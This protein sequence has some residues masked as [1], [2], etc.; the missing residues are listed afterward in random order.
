MHQRGVNRRR[1]TRDVRSILPERQRPLE[2]RGV[3]VGRVRGAGGDHRRRRHPYSRGAK[4]C[5]VYRRWSGTGV[6]RRRF[7]QALVREMPHTL[8]LLQ[9]GRLN[10]WRATLLVR[11]TACLSAADR[12]I[13]DRRL[14]SDPAAAR[15][16]AV[17][18]LLITHLRAS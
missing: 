6:S 5:G 13:V 7:A 2:R 1:K 16:S 10:E 18:T 8:A 14:C 15:D 4:G 12:A 17:E 9:T 3:E 11:E